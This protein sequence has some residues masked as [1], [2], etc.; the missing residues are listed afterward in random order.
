MNTWHDVS[1]LPDHDGWIWVISGTRQF[2]S[3]I[4]S[5]YFKRDEQFGHGYTKLKDIELGVNT[6][7]YWMWQIPAPQFKENK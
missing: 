2:G 4:K 3:K 5:V 6:A 1:E 7:R